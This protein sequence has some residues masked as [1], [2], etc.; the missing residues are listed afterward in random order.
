[1]SAKRSA[2]GATDEMVEAAHAA[3]N[4]SWWTETWDVDVPKGVAR[5]ALEAALHLPATYRGRT[6]EINEAAYDLIDQLGNIEW[7]DSETEASIKRLETALRSKAS[8][9]G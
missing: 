2:V 1:M 3:I 9:S 6:E 5:R 4:K 8:N 7:L